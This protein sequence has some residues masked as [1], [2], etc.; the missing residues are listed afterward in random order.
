M[1]N[2]VQLS[3]IPEGYRL[4][5]GIDAGLCQ[6][7]TSLTLCPSPKIMLFS[8]LPL[9]LSNSNK[10]NSSVKLIGLL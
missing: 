9:L 5:Y 7:L 1:F 3:D 6:V 4:D 10:S 2:R 8:I